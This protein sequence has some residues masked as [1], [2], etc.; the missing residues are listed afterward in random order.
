MEKETW[1]GQTHSLDSSNGGG[2]IH[3]GW[4]R[5]TDLAIIFSTRFTIGSTTEGTAFV[6]T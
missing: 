5:C 1:I 2:E 3:F 6:G 4:V